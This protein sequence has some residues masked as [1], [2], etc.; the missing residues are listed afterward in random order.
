MII[1]RRALLLGATAALTGCDR[2]ARNETVRNALFSAEN[3]HKWAQRS[4]MARDALAQEF[5][6]DQI[7]PVF[8]ANGTANPNTPD[9]KAIWRTGFTDWRLRVVGKVSRPLSLSLSHLRTLPHRE[10][11]TRHDCVEGWSAIGKWRGVPLRT[12]LDAAGLRQDARYIVFHCADD[13]GG[14]RPYYESIDLND[15]FH[16]QTILAFALNDQP[17]SVANGAPL[18][19]RVERQLGYKQAKYLMRIEA[20]ESIAQ[21]G[22]GKGGFWEDYAGYDWYAGI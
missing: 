3:F 2:L 17:L 20:V 22:R 6:P 11:I 21:I 18:R 7:S 14:G 15:A 10:Q 19:L 4:L 13:L 5:R 16:P 1:A 8:R 9:Y 12:I